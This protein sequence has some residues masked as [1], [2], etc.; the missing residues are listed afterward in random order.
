M[1]LWVTLLL[2]VLQLLAVGLAV[3]AF[4]IGGFASDSGAQDPTG[5]RLAQRMLSVPVAVGVCSVLA[6]VLIAF[7]QSTFAAV[8]LMAP[9][10]YFAFVLLSS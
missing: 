10:V 1:K 7:K 5:A 6:W 8:A 4:V 3:L 2:V 9:F